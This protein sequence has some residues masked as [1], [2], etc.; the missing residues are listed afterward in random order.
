M[1]IN[2]TSAL[3]DAIYN[4]EINEIIITEGA[5]R[6]DTPLVI[7][8]RSQELTIKGEGLVTLTATKLVEG[9]WAEYKDGIF[10]TDVGVGHD[11][12]AVYSNDK[13]QIMC[14]FPNYTED[15]ILNGCSCEAISHERISSWKNPS[16]GYMRAIHKNDW[17]GNSYIIKGKTPSNNLDLHW[18]GDNNR[19][20]DFNKNKV[21]VEHIFEELDTPKEWFY[22][23]TEGLLYLMPEIGVDANTCTVEFSTSSD[24]FIIDN[25]QNITFENITFAKTNRTMF[26][27]KYIFVTRSDW[28]VAERGAILL[29]NTRN[30][31]IKKCVF[32][33]IGGN[34]IYFKNRNRDCSVTDCEFINTGASGIIIYGNQSACR[35]LSTW[36]GQNHKTYISDYTKGAKNDLFSKDITI[37]DCYFYNTGIF[38]KQSAPISLSVSKNITI[39]EIGRAS[40]RER[41]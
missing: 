36:E 4:P 24:L 20:K 21:M 40:C 29:N 3:I 15:E 13:M 8:N 31:N 22:D 34:C 10:V 12:Q 6:I 39:K 32:D 19:G 25:S 14:R 18:I 26:N 23:K 37:K 7:S 38:E 41:V 35:N 9:H 27:S 11:I 5:Y 33:R 2:K 30:I 1:I 17:G 16:T 28:G